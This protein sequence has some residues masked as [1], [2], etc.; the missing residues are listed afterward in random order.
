L[1]VLA[2]LG[3]TGPQHSLSIECHDNLSALAG[4]ANELGLSTVVTDAAMSAAWSHLSLED[5][6]ISRL[7][8]REQFDV[9]ER[10][11]RLMSF[12]GYSNNSVLAINRLESIVLSRDKI[13][14]YSVSVRA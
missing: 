7:Q 4:V 12:M 2:A 13:W 14:K 8:V 9:S 3:F 6:K 10:C 5:M 11:E 1:E